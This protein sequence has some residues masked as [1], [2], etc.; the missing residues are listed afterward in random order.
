VAEPANGDGGRPAN[1]TL[2]NGDR[3]TTAGEGSP[4]VPAEEHH[5]K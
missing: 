4:A 3:A 1:G 5:A 2:P